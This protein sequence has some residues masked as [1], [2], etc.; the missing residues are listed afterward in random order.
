[1]T[2][3]H[4]LIQAQSDTLRI[5]SHGEE[6]YKLRQEFQLNDKIIELIAVPIELG[7]PGDYLFVLTQNLHCLLLNY[8]EMTQQP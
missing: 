7:K 2:Y 3:E 5:L 1:M 6:G 8:C 4:N